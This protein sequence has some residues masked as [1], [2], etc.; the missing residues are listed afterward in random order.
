MES[1]KE[2]SIQSCHDIALQIP[3]DKA[4]VFQGGV[5]RSPQ[6]T[7]L[8]LFGPCSEP[9][10]GRSARHSPESRYDAAHAGTTACYC[11]LLLLPTSKPMLAIDARFC[12]RL[13]NTGYLP[14]K[15]RTF[16]EM[17]SSRSSLYVWICGGIARGC[18]GSVVT[19]IEPPDDHPGDLH[20]TVDVALL[21]VGRVLMPHG[22]PLVEAWGLAP[23]KNVRYPLPIL[24]ETRWFSRP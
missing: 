17:R 19:L 4:C 3:G 12:T 10:S 22:A 13:P 23:N 1:T 20:Q 6:E 8:A 2:T 16:D 24:T 14:P 15:G 21:L 7:F 5:L 11:S 9:I 18:P